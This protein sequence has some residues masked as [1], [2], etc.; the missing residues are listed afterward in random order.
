MSYDYRIEKHKIFNDEGFKNIIKIMEFVNKQ[1]SSVF[2]E[3]D[4]TKVCAGGSSWT[5]MAYI[6]F[7]V[8]IGWLIEVELKAEPYGQFRIYRK[9]EKL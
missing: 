2:Q 4:L 8:E 1:E 3:G 9:G 6:H 7:L 5:E